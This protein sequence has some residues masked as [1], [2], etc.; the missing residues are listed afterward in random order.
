MYPDSIRLIKRHGMLMVGRM[1]MA[2]TEP[3]KA[4]PRERDLVVDMPEYYANIN[5][6]RTEFSQ[7]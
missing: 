2:G 7:N 3:L 6:W 4:A 1:L 5:E